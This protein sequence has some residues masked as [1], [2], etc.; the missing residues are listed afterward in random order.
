MNRNQQTHMPKHGV[1]KC[2]G[3]AP[4]HLF[5]ECRKSEFGFWGFVVSLV[6]ALA[7]GWFSAYALFLLPAVSFVFVWSVLSITRTRNFFTVAAVVVAVIELIAW[8][9]FSLVQVNGLLLMFS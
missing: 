3:H 8:L 9:A 1:Y 7:M 6:L 2:K 4:K 5:S